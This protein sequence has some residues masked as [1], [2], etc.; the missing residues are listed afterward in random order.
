MSSEERRERLSRSISFIGQIIDFRLN[1]VDIPG[2]TYSI[3]DIYD[4][5]VRYV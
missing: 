2:Q 4:L 1:D 3:V 5:Y